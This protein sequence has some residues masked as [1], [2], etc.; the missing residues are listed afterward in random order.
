MGSFGFTEIL[1]IGAVVFFLFGAKKIPEFARSLGQGLK[2][3][4]DE[5]HAGSDQEKPKNQS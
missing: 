5:V 3:F 4:K 2:I 1:V